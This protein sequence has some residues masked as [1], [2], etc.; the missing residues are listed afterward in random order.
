MK[1]VDGFI[2]IR[3]NGRAAVPA[4]LE[5]G[6]VKAADGVFGVAPGQSAVLYSPQGFIICG[7]TIEE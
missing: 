7:G 4:T 5:N 3:S 6:A 1:I 2:K